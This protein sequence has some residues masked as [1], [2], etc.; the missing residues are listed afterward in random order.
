MKKVLLSFF[1]FYAISTYAVTPVYRQGFK[2]SQ[3]QGKQVCFAWDLNSVIFEKHV[4]IG[5]MTAYALKEK[6]FF[7]TIKALWTFLKL[8]RHKKNLKKAGDPR[9]FVWD[10]MF[11]ELEKTDPET[12]QLLRIFAQQANILDLTMVTFMQ[13]LSNNGHTHAVLSNMGQ[14]LLDAQVE[15]LKEK[16]AENQSLYNFILKFLEDQRYK[17]IASEDNGWMHKPDKLIYQVFLHKNQHRSQITIFI[18]DKL[19]NV[20]AAI[21]N[22][23]DIGIYYPKGSTSQQLEDILAHE[24]KIAF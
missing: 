21:E 6:G 1:F 20:Q 24:L 16:Q 8:W 2:V 12:A 15:L 22:G 3:A 18:D 14:G 13:N 4:K 19:E 23:F 7:K 5:K 10:A 11:A 9:G 17:V